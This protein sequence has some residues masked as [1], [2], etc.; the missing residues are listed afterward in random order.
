M[1]NHDSWYYY[2]LLLLKC[3]AKGERIVME[4]VMKW[5]AVI[6]NEFHEDT[7]EKM[8]QDNTWGDYG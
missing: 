4:D 3:V 6:Y 1:Y 8:G 2:V 7:V 5:S